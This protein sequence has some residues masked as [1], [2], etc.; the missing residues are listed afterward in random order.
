M[1]SLY[2]NKILIR[3]YIYLYKYKHFEKVRFLKELKGTL[4]FF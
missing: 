4:P 2:Q 1:W 3:P